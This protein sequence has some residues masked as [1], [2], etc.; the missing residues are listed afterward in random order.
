MW[1]FGAKPGKS[2]NRASWDWFCRLLEPRSES[3]Q[4]DLPE[5]GDPTVSKWKSIVWISTAR[6][7]NQLKTCVFSNMLT[8]LMRKTCYL[9]V[10]LCFLFAS[11][12]KCCYLPV[13]PVIFMFL[14]R[15]SWYLPVF[16]VF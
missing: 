4:I 7:G 5:T 12:Q 9:P 10:F 13:F 11:V 1:T 3:H 15:K 16:P 14:I 6:A 2:S 8:G